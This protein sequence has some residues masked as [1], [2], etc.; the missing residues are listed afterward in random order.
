AIERA[1]VIANNL[2]P[3]I[4]SAI[5]NADKEAFEHHAFQIDAAGALLFPPPLSLTPSPE[6]LNLGD[7]TV[8]QM[9]RWQQAER[10]DVTDKDNPVAIQ[11]IRKFLETKPPDRFAAVATYSL[12]VL[13]T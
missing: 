13:L 1:Q 11:A 5:T 3:E 7:L 9:T 2:L 8:E 4:W 10:A 6:P 12:G